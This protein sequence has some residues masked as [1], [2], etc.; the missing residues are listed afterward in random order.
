MSV[1]DHWHPVLKTSDLARGCVR[2]VKLSGYSIAVFR[3]MDGELGAIE[4]KCVHRRMKLS[5]GTIEDDRLVCRYHGWS[6]ESNGQ[7][8]SPATP[9]MHACIASFD[10]GDANGAIWI[11]RPGTDQPLPRLAIEGWKAVGVVINRIKAP[12]QLV[13]DNFSEVEHTVA[14]HPDFGFDARTAGK[15]VVQMDLSDDSITVRNQGPAKMP[16]AGTRVL[17]WVRPGDQFHSNYT[18]RFDPPR[19]SVSHFW[20]NPATGLERMSKYHLFH[21]F[22]PEDEKNTQIV[23]FGFFQSRWP[24]FAHIGQHVGWFVRH[25]IEATVNEDALIL[26]NL[27]D[28]S[29]HLD[30]MKLS[31]FDRVL[32]LTRERIQRIY[33]GGKEFPQSDAGT[34]TLTATSGVT[35]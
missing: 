25:K 24:L 20:T 33:Y 26:E 7:G 15:V 12:L 29:T 4:D 22:V 5:L 1:L 2:G 11:K 30:G 9:Y 17:A 16:P 14:A 8:R 31:R 18:F 6:F 10:C 34:E 23:T 28:D 3:T 21:Y 13:I 19:S 27:A 32:G 35:C